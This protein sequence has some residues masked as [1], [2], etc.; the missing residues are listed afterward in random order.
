MASQ[1]FHKLCAESEDSR[2]LNWLFSDPSRWLLFQSLCFLCLDKIW[3]LYLY[4][5]YFIILYCMM[6]VYYLCLTDHALYPTKFKLIESW[7]RMKA[8][9]L[10]EPAKVTITFHFLHVTCIDGTWRFLIITAINQVQFV[11]KNADS[12]VQGTTGNTYIASCGTDGAEIELKQCFP[13]CSVS[14]QSVTYFT[15]LI[16]RAMVTKTDGS[17]CTMVKRRKSRILSFES[18]CHDYH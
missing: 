3:Y 4:C 10:H 6:Y 18:L 1:L 8:L 9:V 14:S 17:Y 15:L 5:M 16:V 13:S 7:M 12:T 2:N 11:C